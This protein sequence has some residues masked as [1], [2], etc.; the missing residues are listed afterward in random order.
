M[1]HPELIRAQSD[2][3]NA[4]RAWR[5]KYNS[6]GYAIG[7]LITSTDNLSA[8][9]TLQKTAVDWGKRASVPDLTVKE[10]NVLL[11]QAKILYD[12]FAAIVD[13][14]SKATFQA[15]I[16]SVYSDTVADVKRLPADILGAVPIWAR[17]TI[18]L[19]LVLLI[20]VS[21]RR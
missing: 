18:A 19:V 3:N 20:V 1:M 7:Q 10:I 14:G 4:L 2:I 15:A 6:V 16:A 17:V 9:N 8:G 12:G 21:L 5:D 13:I 11:A